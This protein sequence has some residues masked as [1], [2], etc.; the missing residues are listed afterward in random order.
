MAF[1]NLNKAAPTINVTPL[2]DVLLVLLI[3]FMVV[4][5]TQSIGLEALVPDPD[6]KQRSEEPS[7]AV[8]VHVHD[9]LKVTINTEPIDV[10]ELGKRL[11]Q[12]FSTRA[13]RVVFV[14]ADP[15][16]EFKHVAAAIDIAK[17][18]GISNVG[19]LNSS[20]L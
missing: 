10:A 11:I 4:A 16:V 9:D 1:T 2:I 3:I 7:R 18:A 8:V 12:I 5:P 17:G 6:S 15:Q 19:L 13:E 20:R 14:A